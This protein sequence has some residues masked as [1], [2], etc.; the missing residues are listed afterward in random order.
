M[1]ETTDRILITNARETRIA[2]FRK[3]G[4]IVI[5]L[6]AIL[7]QVY[8]PLFLDFLRFL[9]LPLLVTVYFALMRR[10]QLGGLFLGAT[11]GL[12]QDSLSHQP[13]GIF[14]IVKTLIGYWAA[15]IGMLLDVEHVLVRFGLCLLF[16]FAHS[17]LYWMAGRILLGQTAGFD[18][19]QTFFTGLLNAV[20]GIS[21]FHFLDK[22]KERN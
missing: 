22:L 15:S 10:N 20:V 19:Q 8:L 6:V 4:I 3:W 17:L 11:I 5:P 18:I 16:F 13:L 14:G 2:R 7:F 9:E 21:L 12:V 1:S